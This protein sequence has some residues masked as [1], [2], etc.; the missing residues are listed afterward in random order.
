MFDKVHIF[1]KIKD[2]FVKLNIRYEEY[3]SLIKRYKHLVQQ[4]VKMNFSQ[5]VNKQIDINYDQYIR[6]N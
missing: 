2:R 4:L 6:K 1:Y 3:I 5:I